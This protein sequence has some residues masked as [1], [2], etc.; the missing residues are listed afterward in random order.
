MAKPRFLPSESHSLLDGTREKHEFRTALWLYL[1]LPVNMVAVLGEDRWHSHG[2]RLYVHSSL[3]YC[4][5]P[6]PFLPLIP[7]STST[8]PGNHQTH[9]HQC[10][11]VNPFLFLLHPPSPPSKRYHGYKFSLSKWSQ[12]LPLCLFW[13]GQ[14]CLSSMDS[15]ALNGLG[16]CPTSKDME[17]HGFLRTKS[18]G[19]SLFLYA[20][21]KSCGQRLLAEFLIHPDDSWA[22]MAQ[23]DVR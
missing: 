11:W 16:W 12:D 9:C 23:E 1:T 4:I 20:T 13:G 5:F 14:N 17:Y 8:H 6:L 22:Q 19:P 21:E 7:S 3:F 10:P 18:R 15:S 2:S